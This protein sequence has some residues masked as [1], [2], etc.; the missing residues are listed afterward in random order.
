S[1]LYSKSE[2]IYEIRRLGDDNQTV[3][4]TSQGILPEDYDVGGSEGRRSAIVLLSKTKNYV[5]ELG[6][7]PLIS[8]FEMVYDEK[9]RIDEYKYIGDPSNTQDDYTTEISY[10][11]DT[12]LQAK[13]IIAVPEEV[14]VKV[15]NQVKRKRLTDDINLNTG[16]IQT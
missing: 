1:E 3:D 5:Y 4:I 15:N 16:A 12:A 10:H 14:V 13:N 9:G 6:N 11:S 2:N 7:S 8:E